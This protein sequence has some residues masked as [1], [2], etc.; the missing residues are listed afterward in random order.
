MTPLKDLYRELSDRSVLRVAAAYIAVA[1]MVIESSGM[2]VPLFGGDEDAVRWIVLVVFAGFPVTLVLTWVFE[3]TDEGIELDEDVKHTKGRVKGRGFDF[4]VIGLLVVALSISLFINVG[5]DS[6][7]IVDSPKEPLPV[8]I[9]DF[10]NDTGEPLFEGALERALQIGIEGAAFI[11][12]FPRPDA[13]GIAQAILP[14]ASALDSETA[15]LVAAREGISLV[16]S[17]DANADGAGFTVSISA[18]EAHN[19][20]TV[21]EVSAQAADAL[22]VLEAVAQL[23]R[24]I[25]EALGDVNID[26]SSVNETFTAA[27]LEAINYYLTAQALSL[28]QNFEG[29][30]EYYQKAVAEDPEFGRAWSGLALT[31][32]ELGREL[33]AE[34]HYRTALQHL[35]KMTERERLRTMGTYYALSNEN[36]PQAV[37]T[38]RELTGKFPADDAGF[39]NLAVSAFLN[40]QFDE[41]FRAGQQA[42][43][44]FPRSSLYQGNLALYAMYAG[45]FE[46]ARQRAEQLIEQQPEYAMAYL[47]LASAAIAA[48]D[49]AAAEAAYGRMGQ[50]DARGRSIAALGLADLA[51]YRGDLAGAAIQL[52]EAIPIDEAAGNARGASTKRLAL[53]KVLLDQGDP[54]GAVAEANAALAEQTNTRT[55]FQAGYIFAYAGETALAER[56]ARELRTQLAKESRAYGYA[57]DTLLAYQAGDY[58]TAIDHAVRG[59]ELADLWWLRYLTGQTY[60]Q[61]NMYAEA[62]AEFGRC[63]ARLGE[64]AALFLDDLP[65]WAFSYD[66]DYWLGRTQE[67]LGMQQEANDS[68]LRFIERAQTPEADTVVDAQERVTR[69]GRNPAGGS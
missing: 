47:A 5:G 8:L 63:R 44:I 48:E 59:V 16:L 53:A 38:Y 35:G 50:T 55:R 56:Q 34:Q 21:V 65:T 61:M 32:F 51:A 22:A 15:R 37:D 31:E 3:I 58:P 26:P 20:E 40:R 13:L 25:R 11:T 67:S 12:S 57:L 60:I 54:M 45:E 2:L 41:A 6:T 24:E 29:A 9:A 36:Y 18:V 1:W 52:R 46:E 66:V 27:S 19:G 68:F 49:Y 33:E 43:Q 69:L 39:N 10:V 30:I 64:A 4:V 14:D 23:S 42:L 7:P 62:F 17:G 28:E